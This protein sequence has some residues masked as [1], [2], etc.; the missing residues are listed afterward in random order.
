MI[1]RYGMSRG[2]TLYCPIS[3]SARRSGTNKRKQRGKRRLLHHSAFDVHRS[4]L[5]FTVV[6][7]SILAV[8]VLE[9]DDALLSLAQ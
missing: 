6:E 4:M 7:C 9:R 5:I 1:G 2:Y 8:H 3:P